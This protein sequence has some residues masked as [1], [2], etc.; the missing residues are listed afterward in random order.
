MHIHDD[1]DPVHQRLVE[2]LPFGAVGSGDDQVALLA[3]GGPE[4]ETCGQVDDEPRLEL[5]ICDRLT[6]VWVRRPCCD[7]PVHLPHVVARLIL[8]GI[9]RLRTRTGNQA[10]MIAVQHTVEAAAIDTLPTGTPVSVYV[11]GESGVGK[12]SLISRFLDRLVEPE[13]KPLVV[14]R[15][16]GPARRRRRT[17]EARRARR[18][19]TLV[20]GTSKARLPERGPGLRRSRAPRCG[21][22]TGLALRDPADDEPH[23]DP[24]GEASG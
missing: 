20:P 15:G 16:R 21:S 8:A 23:D 7:G 13:G 11:Y 9:S 1:L 17:P 4:V 18:R 10:E 22:I 12:S 19:L 6:H 14:L 3:S 24:G 5:T 2:H